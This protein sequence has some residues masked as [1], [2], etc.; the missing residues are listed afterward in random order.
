VLAKIE[1]GAPR[2]YSVAFETTLSEGS[3]VA[4]RATHIAEANGAL[5][6]GMKASPELASSMRQLGIEMAP[7][8]RGAFPRTPPAGWTWHHELEPGVMR[9]V[10]RAQ[11]TIGS[12]W[13]GAL[14]PA[15]EGGYSIWGR[16]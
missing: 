14:H 5:H 3:R 8:A 10:P 1:G 2:A 13:W 4:S 12:P 15:G 7:G 11:H 16:Q 9:L 6:A